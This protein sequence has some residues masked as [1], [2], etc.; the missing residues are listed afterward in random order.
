MTFAKDPTFTMQLSPPIEWT[1]HEEETETYDEP[2][3]EQESIKKVCKHCGKLND[4][5]IDDVFD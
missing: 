2:T 4:D 5:S 3:A 1:Y